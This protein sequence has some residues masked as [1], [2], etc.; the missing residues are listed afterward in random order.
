[1]L[2]REQ[3]LKQFDPKDFLKNT[4]VAHDLLISV[5]LRALCSVVEEGPPQGL[6]PFNQKTI[7]ERNR[8][9]LANIFAETVAHLLDHN[10]YFGLK[11]PQPKEEFIHRFINK[12]GLNSQS[13]TY[14]LMSTI[15]DSRN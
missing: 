3:N 10:Q 11:I 7:P 4:Q 5:N 2:D 6:N 15:L 13:E 1:M 9:V 14:W 12:Y 8:Y